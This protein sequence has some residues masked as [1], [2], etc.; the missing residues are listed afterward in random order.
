MKQVQLSL[1]DWYPKIDP[2][3]IFD[4][5]RSNHWDVSRSDIDFEYLDRRI[6]GEFDKKQEKTI[7]RDKAFAIKL[8]N[9]INEMI[10]EEKL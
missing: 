4:Y 9:C 2:Y 1:K 5:I 8:I 6:N 10:R 7:C 3:K